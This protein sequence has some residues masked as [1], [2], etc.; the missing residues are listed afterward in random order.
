MRAEVQFAYHRTNDV[1]LHVARAGPRDGNPI[2]LLH[3][4]PESW[5]GWRHQIDALAQAGYRVIV[6]DQRGYNQS[7]RPAGVGSYDLELLAQDITGLARRVW[8]TV[9]C[10]LSATTGALSSAGSWPRTIRRE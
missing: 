7:D 6:P 3:G 9:A 5:Y 1:T 2:M 4:F 8:G 10:M